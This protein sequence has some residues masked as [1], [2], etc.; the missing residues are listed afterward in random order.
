MKKNLSLV[1]VLAVVTSTL[2]GACDGGSPSQQ[3]PTVAAPASA[4]APVASADSLK[5]K[6]SPPEPVPFV[7]GTKA[8]RVLGAHEPS[9]PASRTR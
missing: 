2:L 6:P 4:P 8:G 1:V 7:N 5:F 9:P 3:P